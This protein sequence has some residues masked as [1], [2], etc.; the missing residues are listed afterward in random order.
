M[1]KTNEILSHVNFTLALVNT[2]VFWSVWL[3][4]SETCWEKSSILCFL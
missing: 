3:G 1:Y 4:G 2:R